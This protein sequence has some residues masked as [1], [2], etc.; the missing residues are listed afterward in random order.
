MDR[1]VLIT[2]ASRGIGLATA[3]AF[4]TAGDTVVATMRDTS[5]SG[6]LEAAATAAGVRMQVAELDVVSDESVSKAFTGLVAQYGR[7]DVLVNNAGRGTRGTL[8]EL[9]IDDLQRSLDVNYLGVARVTK[10]A[11]PLMREAARGHLIAVSSVAGFLGQPFQDAYCAAKHAVEGLYES[12]APVAPY[13]SA[14]RKFRDLL[15]RISA[16]PRK[17]VSWR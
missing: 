7:I 17:T 9:T 4:A 2:G 10:A 3:V 12:L 15:P 5:R 13:C 1:I 6:P 16:T 8:E 11:L 14:S